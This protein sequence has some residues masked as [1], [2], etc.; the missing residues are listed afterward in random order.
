[1][2]NCKDLE[3]IVCTVKPGL[4]QAKEN[5]RQ[6]DSSQAKESE[7][8]QHLDL[9][10]NGSENNLIKKEMYHFSAN[11]T[12]SNLLVEKNTDFSS[13]QKNLDQELSLREALK[14]EVKERSSC[15]S[16][17][18]PN[19]NEV[20]NTVPDVVSNTMATETQC[21]FSEHQKYG[22]VGGIGGV[23][24]SSNIPLNIILQENTGNF[25][26]DIDMDYFSTQNPF[27]V[28]YAEVSTTSISMSVLD[29]MT[30]FKSYNN[31]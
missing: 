22:N 16:D 26:L 3:L 24:C 31:F 9:K 7:S 30:L 11:S 8:M 17:T 6:S 28:L 12:A 25:I 13:E 15:K 2:E 29:N 18:D 5:T 4:T 1:M 14:S 19:E 10:D 20:Y 27:K 23:A 21:S